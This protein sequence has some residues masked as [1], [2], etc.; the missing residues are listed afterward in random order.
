MIQKDMKKRLPV[1]GVLEG[2]N[3]LRMIKYPRKMCLIGLPQSTTCKC[4]RANMFEEQGVEMMA[5]CLRHITDIN[6]R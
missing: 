5:K 6:R 3:F 1:A 4:Y 2:K